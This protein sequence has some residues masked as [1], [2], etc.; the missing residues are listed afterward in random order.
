MAANS[1]EHPIVAAMY[2]PVTRVFEWRIR[3]ARQALAA[4][5]TGDVIDIG[6]GTGAMFPFLCAEP[7]VER[8][9]A[10]EPD[11]HMRRRAASRATEC[12]CQITIR[13]DRAEH[14]DLPP[15]SVDTAVM[16]LVGCTILDVSTALD[17]IAR[18]LKGG[19][20]LRFLEHV[21]ATGI[22]AGVQSMIT[23]IWSRVAGGCRLDRETVTII[24]QHPEFT[25]TAVERA[26]G[27]VFPVAP[28]LCGTATVDGPQTPSVREENGNYGG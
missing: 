11:P 21:R 7:A 3:P 12:D 23:P 22:R 17:E 10:I 1:I 5:A 18:V 25:I 6:A 13:D 26:G 2:D 24:E 27:S 28:I 19:G 4:G 14:I 16:S 8:I 20:E 9:I 15:D